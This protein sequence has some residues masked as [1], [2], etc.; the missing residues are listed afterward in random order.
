MVGLCE[1]PQMGGEE[2]I[3]CWDCEG[4]EEEKAK[5]E[6]WHMVRG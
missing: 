6:A 5:A 3:D 4:G 2:E 1:G